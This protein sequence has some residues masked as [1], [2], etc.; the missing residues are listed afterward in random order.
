[1]KRKD[2]EHIWRGVHPLRA[3]MLMRR[4]WSSPPRHPKDK[5][6]KKHGKHGKKAEKMHNVRRSK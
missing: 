2:K 4:L 1:M 3:W 5:A 6:R